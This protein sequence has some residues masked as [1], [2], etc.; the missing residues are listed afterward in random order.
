M[1]II[2]NYMYHQFYILRL[3]LF[4]STLT[5]K[6]A[7]FLQ[8]GDSSLTKRDARGTK[9]NPENSVRTF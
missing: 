7:S 5:A 2:H 1:P 9:N 6:A 8:C 4:S 3:T